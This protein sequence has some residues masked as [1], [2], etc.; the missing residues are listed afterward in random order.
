MVNHLTRLDECY[1]RGL[2]RKVAASNDKAMQSLAQSRENRPVSPAGRF[3]Y[4]GIT[5]HPVFEKRVVVL[6]NSSFRTQTL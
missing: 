4:L 6:G 3:A 2:L 1:D 5:S